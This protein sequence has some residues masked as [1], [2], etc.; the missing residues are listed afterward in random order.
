MNSAALNVIYFGN[1]RHA[2]LP[3]T[4]LE[5]RLL[6]MTVCICWVLVDAANL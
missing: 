5:V 1:H 3:G 4:Y 6:K 2:R